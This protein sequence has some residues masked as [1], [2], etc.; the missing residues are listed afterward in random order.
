MRKIILIVLLVLLGLCLLFVV[1]N[2]FDARPL[3]GMFGPQDLPAANFAYENGYYRLWTLGMDG[4]VDV[5][6][7]EVKDRYRRLFDPRFDNDREIRAFNASRHNKVE[8]NITERLGKPL[9]E[10]ISKMHVIGDAPPPP[11]ADMLKNRAEFIRFREQQPVLLERY[12]RLLASDFFQ[13]FGLLRLD[14]PLPNLITWLRLAKLRILL[15]LVDA[16]DGKWAEAAD[17]LLAQMQFARKAVAGSSVLITNL[18]AKAV[19]SLSAQGLA[20]LM[21]QRECPVEVFSQ[22]LAG[23]P[24]LQYEEYGSRNGFIGEFLVA[25]E[26][27]GSFRLAGGETVGL[28]GAGKFIASLGLQRNRTL[29]EYCEYIRTVLAMESSPLPD[30]PLRVI[31]P[32][33]H[34]QG[35]FWWAQN[36]GG[37]A[38]LDHMIPNL[39]TVV[40][41]AFRVKALVDM[42][43]ISAEL[44][45]RYDPRRTVRENLDRLATYQTMDPCSG[46]PYIWSE[47]K[48]VLYSVGLDRV[49]GGGSHDA[50]TVR[51]DVV[52][53]VIL[54]VRAQAE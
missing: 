32:R 41:K 48:Q 33:R 43:R 8:T 5:E 46:K 51:T 47:D 12:R 30:D 36:P 29:N 20:F 14:C 17:A 19:L 52:L 3:P 6:A 4:R 40:F 24:P 34:R 28:K 1:F 38:V 27:I 16:A 37:K 26:I 22:A 7:V 23:M 42:A 49:D 53:P 39:G 15:S 2:R 25:R 54:Y 10:A 9:L 50:N 44:H 35:A 11:Q 45:L 13:D 21:N 31:E 18:V